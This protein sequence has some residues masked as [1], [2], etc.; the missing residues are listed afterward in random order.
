MQVIIIIIISI[1]P[2]IHPMHTMPLAIGSWQWAIDLPRLSP[3]C[4][5]PSCFRV[6]I[7]F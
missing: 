3:G 5:L 4:H 6:M 2:S 7:R 1:H